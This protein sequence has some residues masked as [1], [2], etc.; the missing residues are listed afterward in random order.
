MATLIEKINADLIAAMKDRD[1]AHAQER[2]MTL[3]T[4]R[5]LNAEIKTFQMNQKKPAEDADVIGLLTRAIKQF[6]ETLDKATGGNQAGIVRTDIA[7]QEKAKI[8]LLEKYLPAQLTESEIVALIAAAIQATGASS[9]KD[10]G[11][12]MAVIRPQTAG[13]AEG[14]LVSDLV[15]KSLAG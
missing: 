8:A 1:P 4:L 2:E 5:T 9:P 6:R 10:M 11:A 3:V 14:K 15:K 7:E 12:V 13:K